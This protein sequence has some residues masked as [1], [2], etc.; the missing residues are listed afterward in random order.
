[1]SITINGAVEILY[2]RVVV[3]FLCMQDRPAYFKSTYF[4]SLGVFTN[5][6]HYPR[7][8]EARY[9]RGLGWAVNVPLAHHQVHEVQTTTVPP[10][11]AL[12]TKRGVGKMTICMSS[13]DHCIFRDWLL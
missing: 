3:F 13:H 6:L 2:E 11:T 9:E 7:A 12:F 1:M 5:G 4:K 8:F 10:G